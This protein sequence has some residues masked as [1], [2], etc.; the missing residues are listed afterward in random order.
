MQEREDCVMGKPRRVLALGFGE[1]FELLSARLLLLNFRAVRAEL[2][3]EGVRAMERSGEPI[4]S[5]LLSIPHALGDLDFALDRLRDRAPGTSLRFVAVG[6]RPSPRELEELRSAGVEFS[7]WEPFDDSAL[8]FVLNA[9][10]RD[11]VSGE[12]RKVQRAPHAMLARVFSGAGQKAAL[13]YNLS[14]HGAFLETLRP[15]SAK[16][17][18]RVELPLPSGTVTLEAEVVS[19]NVPGNLQKPHVPMG[20]GVV[21][22]DVPEEI[23]RN[24]AE[25]VDALAEEFYI[26]KADSG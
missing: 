3:D 17:H 26:A 8:R 25:L 22:V 18:V 9:A 13:V 11:P 23:R 1:E 7:L 24:L 19:T 20:M 14:E 5:V 2:A 16:G 21:F 4:R 6:P 15:T 12:L 10:V